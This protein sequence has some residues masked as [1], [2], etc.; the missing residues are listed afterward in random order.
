M[1]HNTGDSVVFQSPLYFAVGMHMGTFGLKK[2]TFRSM[3]Q[4]H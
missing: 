1:I 4:K 2:L 3:P